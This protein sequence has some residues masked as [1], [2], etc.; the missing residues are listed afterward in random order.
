[1]RPLVTFVKQ[2]LIPGSLT[3]LIAGLVVGLALLSAGPMAALWGRAWLAALLVLYWLLSLP[4][5]SHALLDWLQ[6]G[7]KTLATPHD[8]HGANVLVVVGN[9]CVHYTAGPFASH[10]LTRRSTFCAFEAARLYPLI[11]P[12]WIIATGGSGD[13]PAKGSSEAELLR[14]MMVKCLVPA[15]RILLESTSTT[16]D[17]QVS[18]VLQLL[19]QHGVGGPMV[20]VTTPAH[21]SRVMK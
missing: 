4:A 3:F 13:S 11:R 20:V 16:T 19:R 5:V 6:Q 12:D 21:M 8:A 15:D 10:Q 1:M 7:Y 17:E 9:G 14:D 18:N 2:F